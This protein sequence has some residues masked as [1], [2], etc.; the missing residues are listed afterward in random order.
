MEK[1]RVEWYDTRRLFEDADA[2]TYAVVSKQNN[3][4]I[5]ISSW[6]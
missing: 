2:R 5:E 6:M 1:R 4:D 3:C